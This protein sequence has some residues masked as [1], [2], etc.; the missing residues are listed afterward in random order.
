MLRLISL[1]FYMQKFGSNKITNK[2]TREKEIIRHYG[3]RYLSRLTTL[4]YI[5]HVFYYYSKLVKC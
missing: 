1:I 3:F 2:S 5:K 4:N